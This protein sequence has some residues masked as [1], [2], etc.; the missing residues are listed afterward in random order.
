MDVLLFLQ[1]AAATAETTEIRKRAM[2]AGRNAALAYK[3]LL[4]SVHQVCCA[5]AH[6]M[7]GTATFTHTYICIFVNSAKRKH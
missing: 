4:E 3:E 2:N 5:I 7:D 1:G 6:C